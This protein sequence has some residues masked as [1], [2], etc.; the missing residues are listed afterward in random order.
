MP[1]E[2]ALRRT[3]DGEVRVYQDRG[4]RGDDGKFNDFIWRN[5]DFACDCNRYDFF[6]HAGGREPDDE[7]SENAPCGDTAYSIDYI[8]DLETGEIVYSEKS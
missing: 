1:I 6:E 8:K 4:T 7:E 3:A 5:D 2:I